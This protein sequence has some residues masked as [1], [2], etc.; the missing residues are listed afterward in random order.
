MNPID[1]QQQINELRARLE[2]LE[3]EY[4]RNNFT[5][6]QD[7]NKYSNFTTRLKVP[8][9]ASLPTTC[10]VGEIA[11]SAGKLRVCS[12]TDTWTIVGTQS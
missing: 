11:E 6:N 12:A 2:Q 7:F 1:S 10:Q 4:F 3:S 9:Y 5:A 8:H